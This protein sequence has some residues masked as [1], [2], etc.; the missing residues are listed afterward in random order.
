MFFGFDDDQLA[1]RD[2]V[3]DLLDKECPPEVVRA[4]WSAPAGALDR[5]VWD[6]LDEMGVLGTLVTEAHGGL[7][8]DE[9]SL[10]LVLEETGRAG[11]PHPV[12]ETAAVAAPLLG[13]RQGVGLV[14]SDLGG[15]HVPCAADADWLLLRDPA[16]GALHLVDSGAVALTPVDTVDG[17][18]RAAGVDWQPSPSTLITD[19]PAAVE[20]AF[21]RGAWGAAAQL[22]GLGQRMLDTT[23]AYVVERQQFGVPIGSFQAVKHH[24]ADALKELAFARP[25]VHRAAHSLATGAATASRDVSMAKAMASDAAWFVGRQALQCHGAIGY[26]VEHDLHLYLKRTWALAKA[27]GDAAWHRDRVGNAIGI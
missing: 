14:A 27:W 6:R 22:V 16:S 15:P 2:A 11:L 9:R 18:R 23:V 5:A 24:L 25:A 7:G 21:D 19:D 3:R 13:E 20:L 17:A 26:T 1:F 4:A 8:L 10:V 12:V